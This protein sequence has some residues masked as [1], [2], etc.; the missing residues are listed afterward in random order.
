MTT[1]LL[2]ARQIAA[3]KPTQKRAEYGD[4]SPLGLWLRV[5]SH[6]AK[7][8]VV[9]YRHRGR[10]LRITLASLKVLS[11]AD[12]RERARDLLHKASEGIDV[13]TEKQ[14]EGGW[15][16]SA[17]SRAGLYIAKWAKPRKR[18]WK[19]DDNLLRKKILPKWRHRAIIDIT[20]ADVR[21]LVE[22]VAEAGSP[23][24]AN[25]VAA[26]LSKLFDFARDPRSRDR[27]SGGRI[28]RAKRHNATAS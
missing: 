1:R 16:R 12:A 19:A 17:I 3:I 25:R 15:I 13:A 6:G 21:L 24:V 26:L 8:W 10:T 7:T 20:R 22:G 14:A 4:E 23:V 27:Q 28:D 11:L 18:S 5:T 2:T 9:R